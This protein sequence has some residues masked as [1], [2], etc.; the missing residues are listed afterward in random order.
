MGN[1]KKERQNCERVKGRTM[2]A[3]TEKRKGEGKQA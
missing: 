1:S 2:G 3:R